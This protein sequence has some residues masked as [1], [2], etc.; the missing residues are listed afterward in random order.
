MPIK[1]RT[2]IRLGSCLIILMIG[3]GVYVVYNPKAL[4]LT[5]LG[6]NLPYLVNSSRSLVST[7]ISSYLADYLWAVSF[8]MIIQSIMDL[9]REWI[10]LLLLCPLLGVI[11]EVMQYLN[12]MS[13]TSDILDVL[14][15]YLGSLTVIMMEKF[16]QGGK[17]YEES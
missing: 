14:V 12:W 16:F 7:M 17:K 6:V 2:L 1:K 5:C 10:C 8:T 13:G 4:F 11:F 3:A 9:K 15:Y